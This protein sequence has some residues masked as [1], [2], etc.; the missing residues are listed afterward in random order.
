MR[1]RVLDLRRE[2]GQVAEAGAGEEAGGGGDVQ[3]VLGARL[4]AR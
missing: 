2:R 1:D 3:G 4:P